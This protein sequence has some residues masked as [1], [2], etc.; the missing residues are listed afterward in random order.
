MTIKSI[1]D[2]EIVCVKDVLDWCNSLPLPEGKEKLKESDLKFNK[3]QKSEI[4]ISG[5]CLITVFEK[6][7]DI[8]YFYSFSVNKLFRKIMKEVSFSEVSTYDENN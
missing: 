8:V 1:T 5:S 2:F 7:I 6:D 3:I 4:G